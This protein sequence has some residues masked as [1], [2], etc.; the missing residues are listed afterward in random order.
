MKRMAGREVI[1]KGG[2]FKTE[3]Q[4]VSVKVVKINCGLVCLRLVLK[5]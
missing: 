3:E 1:R 4:D 5:I 2:S